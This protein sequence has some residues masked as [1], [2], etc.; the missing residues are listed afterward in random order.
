MGQTQIRN[1]SRNS[2][3]DDGGDAD[4]DGDDGD[5]GNG[6]GGD[7]DGDE[8][9]FLFSEEHTEWSNSP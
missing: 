7:G 2:Y 1:L 9:R 4:G 3:G 6:D 8:R 5:G